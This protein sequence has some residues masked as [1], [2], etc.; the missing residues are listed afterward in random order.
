[1]KFAVGH[2]FSAAKLL[3][4]IA[5]I[6][7]FRKIFKRFGGITKDKLRYRDY[8]IINKKN[9]IPSLF[10]NQAKSYGGE[11]GIRIPPLTMLL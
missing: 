7:S 6:S 3:T 8:L 4:N 11:T 10:Q 9:L 2:G 5:I 1:L